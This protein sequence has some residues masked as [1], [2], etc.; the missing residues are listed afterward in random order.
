MSILPAAVMSDTDRSRA[1]HG[2]VNLRWH[3]GYSI[4]AY[5]LCGSRGQANGSTKVLSQSSGSRLQPRVRLPAFSLCAPVLVK[6]RHGLMT[7][8]YRPSNFLPDACAIHP[9][10]DCSRHRG[11]SLRRGSTCISAWWRQVECALRSRRRMTIRGAVFLSR[12]YATSPIFQSNFYSAAHMSGTEPRWRSKQSD[13]DDCPF[14]RKSKAHHALPAGR[15]H[16]W[17]FASRRRKSRWLRICHG[18]AHI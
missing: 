14:A 17:P 7:P 9:S 12:P 3:Y 15:F 13:F 16:Y 18:R 6:V 4:C 1:S 11:S 8:N 10:P 5:K 2:C